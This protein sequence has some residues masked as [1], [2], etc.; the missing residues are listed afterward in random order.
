MARVELG[1]IGAT[2]ITSEADLEAAVGTPMAT[3]AEAVA[4]AAG[5]LQPGN[6]LSDLG[7]AGAAWSNLGGDSAAIAAVYNNAGAAAGELVTSDGAGGFQSEDPAN[8]APA[9]TAVGAALGATALQPGRTSVASTPYTVLVSDVCLTLDAGAAVINLPPIAAYG[10][11]PLAI[12]NYMAATRTI[13]PDG[14]ET[15]LLA[16]SLDLTVLTESVILRPVS[17]TNWGVF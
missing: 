11:R 2:S 14:A 13:N 9:S 7:S 12:G 6:N 3:E 17:A 16:A 8:F 5:A 15:I 4:A 10:N 1:V